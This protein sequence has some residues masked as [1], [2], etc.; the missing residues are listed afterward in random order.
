MITPQ[1]FSGCSIEGKHVAKQI[2]GEDKS[3]RSGRPGSQK[4]CG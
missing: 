2:T 3:A 4:R 1:D